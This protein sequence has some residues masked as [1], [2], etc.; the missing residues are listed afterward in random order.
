MA[1][2]G[3]LADQTAVLLGNYNGTPLHTVSIL[4]GLRKEFSGASIQYVAGTQ[5]LGS[6]A[7]P[8][9]ASALSIDGKLGVNVSYSRIDMTNMNRPVVSAPIITPDP[10]EASAKITLPCLPRWLQCSSS[11]DRV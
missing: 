6:D 3:P 2:V 9:P 11:C 8:V 5:F 4:E 10:S 7:A 1:V